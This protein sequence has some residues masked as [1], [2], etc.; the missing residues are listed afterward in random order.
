MEKYYRKPIL[1]NVVVNIDKS[2]IQY[3]FWVHFQTN[4]AKLLLTNLKSL[5]YRTELPRTGLGLK[6][7]KL[8]LAKLLET[9]SFSSTRG[10]LS[11]D[12]D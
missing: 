6:K 10:N 7:H 5:V 4:V 3:S 1:V 2:I 11:I 12:F 9:L 8:C